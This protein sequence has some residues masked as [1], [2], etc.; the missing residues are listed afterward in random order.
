[1][2]ILFLSNAGL[3]VYASS[4][5]VRYCSFHNAFHLARRVLDAA[6]FLIIVVVVLPSIKDN[7]HEHRK[8]K[9]DNCQRAG[10]VGDQ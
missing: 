3:S 10:V 7:Q 4:H 8:G 5:D 2:G 6:A 1:L 9:D